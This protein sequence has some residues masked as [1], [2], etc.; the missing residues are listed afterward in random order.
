M[1]REIIH[2]KIL[3]LHGILINISLT[4]KQLNDMLLLYYIAH[5]DISGDALV[6]NDSFS[7][8]LVRLTNEEKNLLLFQKRFKGKSNTIIIKEI[9]KLKGLND[10]FT[11]FSLIFNRDEC[12]KKVEM[13]AYICNVHKLDPCKV[14]DLIKKG[15]HE[16]NITELNKL[17]IN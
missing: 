6:Y 5:H 1:T 14:M 2:A 8:H 15:E 13:L 16:E 17:E 12:V 11:P 9:E 4:H 7:L 10:I 3:L